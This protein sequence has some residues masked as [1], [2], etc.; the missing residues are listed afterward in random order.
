MNKM[1]ISMNKII[2]LLIF[3]VILNGSLT[4]CA[5]VQSGNNDTEYKISRTLVKAAVTTAARIAREMKKL[6]LLEEVIRTAHETHDVRMIAQMRKRLEDI[7]GNINTDMATYDEILSSLITFNNVT[8]EKAL[9]LYNMYLN[10][11]SRKN[12]AQWQI[13]VFPFVNKHYLQYNNDKKGNNDAWRKDFSQIKGVIA[14][15]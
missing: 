2:Q 3:V 4:G 9:Y 5:L 6:P 14:Q 13:Q 7:N 11:S 10:D 15:D 8:I 12:T 1:E